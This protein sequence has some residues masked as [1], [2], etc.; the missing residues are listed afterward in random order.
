MLRK[1]CMEIVE[2]MYGISN[3]NKIREVKL[4]LYYNLIHIIMLHV[5]KIKLQTSL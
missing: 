3:N 1:T 4:T 2:K 5:K